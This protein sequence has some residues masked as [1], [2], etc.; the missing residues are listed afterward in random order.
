M[1]YSPWGR[2]ESDRTERFH[3]APVP[4][5]GTQGDVPAPEMTLEMDQ[6]ASAVRRA[7]ASR[8]GLRATGSSRQWGGP[9]RGEAV[10]APLGS[11]PGSGGCLGPWKR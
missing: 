9:G 3:L 1:G 4:R 10:P 8:G 2:K 7:G 6:V 11:A 5:K